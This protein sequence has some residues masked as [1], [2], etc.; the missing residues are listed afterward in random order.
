MKGINHLV[1]TG[2][3]LRAMRDLYEGLGFTLTAAG[4]HPFGTGNTIIQLRGSYLELLAVTQPQ[5][6]VEHGRNNFSFSAFNRDYLARHEGFSMLV[7]DTASAADDIARWQAEG[8]QTYAPFEFSRKA[9]LPDGADV[10]VGFQLA[11]VSNPEAPWLGLFACQHFRPDYYAQPQFMAHRN[12]AKRLREVW[13]CAK[14]AYRFASYLSIVTSSSAR[15]D[16][17]GQTVIPTRFGEIILAEADAFHAAFGTDPPHPQDGPH[18]AGFTI[19][20]SRDS[21]LPVEQLMECS[22][23]WVL[24]PSRGF[25]TAIA[26]TWE[27]SS[28]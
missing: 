18:L 21:R 23:R 3:D 6:V 11:F 4:Q 26:F 13:I 7:L 22:G 27:G 5:D 12:G 28:Q 9:R 19:E 20:C 24:P 17:P 16:E 15:T 14:D 2:R 25:E 10:T 1:L 8:L